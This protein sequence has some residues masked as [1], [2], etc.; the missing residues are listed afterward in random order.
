MH[1]AEG[2]LLR[3]RTQGV[4]VR[5]PTYPT[6]FS[7]PPFGHGFVLTMQSTTSARLAT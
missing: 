1:D 2:N 4:G 3:A 6:R 7:D 5:K